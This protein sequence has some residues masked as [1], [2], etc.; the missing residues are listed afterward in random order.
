MCGH[1]KAS[2]EQS[3][4]KPLNRLSYILHV[5]ISDIQMPVYVLPQVFKAERNPFIPWLINF[6]D[7]D[8]DIAHWLQW[9]GGV[10]TCQQ[11]VSDDTN[12]VIFDQPKAVFEVE[13]NDKKTLIGIPVQFLKLAKP[14]AV[15]KQQPNTRNANQFNY[16]SRLFLSRD[17]NEFPQRALS[18][19]T[20]A[21][22]TESITRAA[23]VRVGAGGGLA[24]LAAYGILRSRNKSKR[25]K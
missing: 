25:L 2:R 8:G 9:K 20:Q 14:V 17:I 19:K 21:E 16:V 22:Y 15:D 13:M 24:L 18:L 12:P 6:K 10:G 3:R 4:G 23:R 7:E 5:K 1:R 11:V